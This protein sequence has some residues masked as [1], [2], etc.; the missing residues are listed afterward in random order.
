M[1]SPDK[2]SSTKVMEALGTTMN[3]YEVDDLMPALCWL[4][5]E[6]GAQYTEDK[7]MFLELVLRAVSSAY[8]LNDLN[9]ADHDTQ[10]H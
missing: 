5:G 7:K 1:R 4:L 6:V 8:D 9:G 3:G 2:D 10:V